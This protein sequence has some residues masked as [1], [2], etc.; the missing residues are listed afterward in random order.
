MATKLMTSL[1]EIRG[2]NP[3]PIGWAAILGARKGLTGPFPLIECL[4]SN[5]FSDVCWLLGKRAVQSEVVKI[6]AKAARDCASSVA[7]LQNSQHRAARARAADAA[8]TAA[9]AT[10]VALEFLDAAEDAAENAAEDAAAHDFAAH[11]CAH[12]AYAARAAAFAA[13]D[14]APFAAED[15]PRATGEGGAGADQRKVNMEILRQASL[16]YE[17][18]T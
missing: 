18:K 7:H 10:K 6:L 8:F 16:N 11:A 9:E 14:A 12:A 5:T 4:A 17:E 1:E 3:C 13:E 2:F 15:A